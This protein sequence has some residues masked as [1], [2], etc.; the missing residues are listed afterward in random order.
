M[1]I[2]EYMFRLRGNSHFF[3]FV[4]Y[5]Q[6]ALVDLVVH[7]ITPDEVPW[8]HKKEDESVN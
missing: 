5:Y 2:T 8:T 1:I 7:P 6:A 3:I 4:A